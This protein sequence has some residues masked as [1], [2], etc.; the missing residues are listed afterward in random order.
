M[1][2]IG[3]FE[4][5]LRKN[6]PWIEYLDT[7]DLLYY[8]KVHHGMHDKGEDH[9]WVHFHQ[10]PPDWERI[11]LLLNP[12]SVRPWFTPVYAGTEADALYYREDVNLPMQKGWSTHSCVHLKINWAD[13]TAEFKVCKHGDGLNGN[14]VLKEILPDSNKNTPVEFMK[15]VRDMIVKARLFYL[16]ADI[17]TI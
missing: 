4:Q 3:N 10:S 13:S 1:I 5:W 12:L 11:W 14:I 16:C 9:L 17:S 15:W 8:C 7:E 2:K 6:K